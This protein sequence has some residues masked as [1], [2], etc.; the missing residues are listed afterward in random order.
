MDVNIYKYFLQTQNLDARSVLE[1][2]RYQELTPIELRR[3]FLLFSRDCF[4]SVD[5]YNHMSGYEL[6]DPPIQYSVDKYKKN[7][8]VELDY[9]YDGEEVNLRPAV[10]L[11]LD[12][13][14]FERQVIGDNAGF[15]EDNST[16]Y[17]TN[18]S[19]TNLIIRHISSSP[20]L[21]YALA[22]TTAEYYLSISNLL[23]GG[24][25]GLGDFK[26]AAIS[27]IQLTDPERERN[28]RV[29]VVFSLAFMFAW[30]TTTED[31]RLKEIRIDRFG[32]E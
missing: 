21:S 25:P 8:D 17:N 28:Y 2:L 6:T 24:L 30:S 4:S 11:G 16:E 27:K 22:N 3:I 20:D 31:Q 19:N 23:L 7:L 26:L 14:R 10:F 29:D 15:S 13:I 9:V 32:N 1:K 18:L 12:D 5:N